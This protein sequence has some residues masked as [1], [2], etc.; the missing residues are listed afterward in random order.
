MS[1]FTG[2]SKQNLKT[3]IVSDAPKANVTWT[4]TH[5][6]I[7]RSSLKR[8]A[9]NLSHICFSF[10]CLTFNPILLTTADAADAT[11]QPLTGKELCSRLHIREEIIILDPSGEKVIGSISSEKDLGQ[12]LSDSNSASHSKNGEECRSSSRSGHRF[13]ELSLPIYFYHQWIVDTEGRISVTYDQGSGHNGEGKNSKLVGSIGEK[14]E[15]IKNFQAISWVSPF[16][17]KERVVIRLTP[18]LGEDQYTRNLEKFPLLLSKAVIFDGQGRLWA[19]NLDARGDFIGVK[20]LVSGLQMSYQKFPGADRIGKVAGH[21]IRIKDRDGLSIVVKSEED[22][23]PGN[24]RSELYV[25]L[26]PE[27]RSESVSSLAVSTGS[28]AEDTFGRMVRSSR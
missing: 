5:H 19:A 17:K 20:T 9:I 12:G 1:V 2:A 10:A 13:N 27:L 24:L 23:L 25:K 11:K 16:H 8:W 21:E 22:I 18:S 28:E 15:R 14:T 4:S 26:D 7:T 6:P 3:A